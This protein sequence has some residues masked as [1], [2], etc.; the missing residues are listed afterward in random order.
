MARSRLDI[1]RLEGGGKEKCGG[2]GWMC[3]KINIYY[4]TIALTDAGMAKLTS[5]ELGTYSEGLPAP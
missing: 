4:M 5:P 2:G 1:S 3:K